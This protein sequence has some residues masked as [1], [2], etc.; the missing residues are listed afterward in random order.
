MKGLVIIAIGGNSLIKDPQHMSVYD[1]YKAAG[2]TSEHIAGVVEQGYRVVITHGNG[3]QVGFILLRS[4]MA[5]QVLHEVPLD[6]CGADTQGA[7]GYQICQTLG[8]ELRRRGIDRTVTAV[9]TQ[10]VVDRDDPGF[11]DPTK[12]IGPFYSAESATEHREREG[13]IM[14]EDSGRGWRRVVASPRPLEIVEEEA[15]RQ[16]LE[17]Q[18]VVV[19]AGGGGI[20]VVRNDDGSLSGIGAVIDKDLSSCLLA[21]NLGADVFLISTSVD[22]VALGYRKPTQRWIDRMT[23]AEAKSYLLNG[24]FADGSMKPKIEASI[25]FLENGGKKVIITQP[26]MLERALAGEAGTHI[27]P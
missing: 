23:V 26:E 18:I 3:P 19:A 12:P 24:E 16:L 27:E 5:K 10:T 8:N 20:P 6:T 2:E 4:E 21:K 25:D 1:Q 22:R 7:I 14:R 11:Q 15:I 13:W 17:D 9:V